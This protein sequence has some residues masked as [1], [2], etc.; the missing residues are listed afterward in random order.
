MT[1]ELIAVMTSTGK[2]WELV[3][4]DDCSSDATWNRIGEA[5]RID[6]RIRGLRH[7]RNCGQSA[8]L[9]TGFQRTTSPIVATL[10]GD[11]QN[12][13]GDLPR[14]LEQLASADFVSGTRTKR[15]DS[16]VRR[17][18]SKIAR[19]ARRAVLKVDIHDSGCAMRVFRRTTLTAAFP[20]NGLH[21]F[22]PI[23]VAS[24]GFKTVQ[25]P[26]NHRPRNAGISKYGIG[27]RAWRGFLDLLAIAWFQKRRLK[28][29][30]VASTDEANRSAAEEQVIERS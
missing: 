2:T 3:F 27:N 21:R 20:F 6:G 29:V 8:A 4:V 17:A 9:W 18:S 14:M 28:S 11:L 23:L 25:I 5:R 13:A 22:L 19:L 12:D 10:D 15:A 1:R 24:G 26:V 16:W 7:L 30:D